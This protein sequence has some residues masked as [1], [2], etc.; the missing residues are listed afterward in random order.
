MVESTAATYRTKLRLRIAEYLG[1]ST[2]SDEWTTGESAKLDRIIET[3]LNQF[4]LAHDWNFLKPELS[5]T[6]VAQQEDQDLPD[7]FAYLIGGYLFHAVDSGY[8]PVKII[9]VSE[10]L[11][12]RTISTVSTV[13][14]HAAIRAKSSSGTTG[15]RYEIMWWPTPSDAYTLTGRYAVNP[16]ALSASAPYPLGGAMHAATIEASCLAVAELREDNI[17]GPMDADYKEKLEQS[18][19]KDAKLAPPGLLSTD[20]DENIPHGVL[21]VVGS[22]EDRVTFEGTSY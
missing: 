9:S 2:D 12:Q 5:L 20:P 6:T 11:N 8:S 21:H 3:G 19:R 13:P 18:I 15:Q 16:D 10:I 1:L 4:Y 7:D 22:I 17:K 14:S